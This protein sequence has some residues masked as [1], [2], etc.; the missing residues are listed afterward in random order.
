MKTTKLI[1]ITFAVIPFIFCGCHKK[2]D[3]NDL[4]NSNVRLRKADSIVRKAVVDN[5]YYPNTYDSKSTKVDSAFSSI[6]TPQVVSAAYK[7][8]KAKIEREPVLTDYKNKKRNVDFWRGA[9][10]QF[11]KNAREDLQEPA[12][13]L[14]ELNKILAFGYLS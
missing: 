13:K 14:Q 6:Y 4:S 5:L 8:I 1:L 7:I 10:R 3:I 12:S 2:V 9:N 11:Y